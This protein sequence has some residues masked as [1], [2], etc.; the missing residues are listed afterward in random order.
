MIFDHRTI[1]WRVA[2]FT[3]AAGLL[4]GVVFGLA[5]ALRLSRLNSTAEFQEGRAIWAGGSIPALARCF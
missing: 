4:T 1:D 3:I 5:P 2:S